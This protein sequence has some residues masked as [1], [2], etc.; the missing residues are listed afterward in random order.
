MSALDMLRTHADVENEVDS[1]GSGGLVD[2][3]IY[4][5]IVEMAYFSKAT[6]GAMA[7]NVW[8]KTEEGRIIRNTM[9][10]TSGDAKGNKNYYETK[11]GEKR[12][13][14][15]MNLANSLA[16]LTVGQEI[17]DLTPEQKIVPI[18]DFEEKKDINQEVPVLTALLGKPIKAGV[19]KQTVSKRVKQ[20]DG[21]YA[22]TAETREENEIDKFFRASDNMTV[23]EARANATEA[24]F[25]NTWSDKW[26]GVTRDKTDKDAP[27]PGGSQPGAF[28]TS[29]AAPTP[30][31][32]L[33]AKPAA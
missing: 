23:T 27:A 1:V 21:T 3:G 25:I 17:A 31:E 26:T 16:I 19:L 15:G 28:G 2:S 5:S 11:D 22:A 6:S 32:S 24:S 33:F 9:Y 14:P 8:L 13:L 12:Y 30:T 7:L 4:N 29:G 18:Y 20:A 10:V